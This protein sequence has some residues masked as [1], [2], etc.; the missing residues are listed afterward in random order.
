MR[1]ISSVRRVSAGQKADYAVNLVKLLT[2]YQHWYLNADKSNANQYLAG[3]LHEQEIQDFLLVNR[4]NNL[5]WFNKDRFEDMLLVVFLHRRGTA[6]GDTGNSKPHPR[7]NA[8]FDILHY[9]AG[10]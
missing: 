8:L 3:L 2:A 6:Y 1:R 4:Y 5:L 9:L 10:A 7:I